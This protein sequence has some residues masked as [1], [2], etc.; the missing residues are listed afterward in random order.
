MVG[1][2]FWGGKEIFCSSSEQ[3]APWQDLGER[4]APHVEA[5]EVWAQ[6]VGRG[7]E[8]ERQP[9]QLRHHGQPLCGQAGVHG[10]PRARHPGQRCGGSHLARRWTRWAN[11]QN[12]TLKNLIFCRQDHCLH[13]LCLQS[14]PAV[15]VRLKPAQAGLCRPLV[16]AEVWSR[17]SSEHG[18]LQ[19]EASLWL[20]GTD[21]GALRL[22]KGDRSSQPVE[23]TL[24]C[25][26]L[27]GDGLL[28]THIGAAHWLSKMTWIHERTQANTFEGE[29][30]TFPLSPTDNAI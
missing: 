25:C 22:Y 13:R 4:Q 9:A 11:F 8:G 5:V 26:P 23:E 18:A 1:F 24:Q 28:M 29:V 17:H 16:S 15:S 7:R 27:R 12:K 14:G 6:L 20:P 3:G 21:E 2:R 10:G 19:P 30:M